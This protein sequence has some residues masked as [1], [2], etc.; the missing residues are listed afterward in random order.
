MAGLARKD[1]PALTDQERAGLY[2]CQ[3]CGLAQVSP[4]PQPSELRRH[5]REEYLHR[6]ETRSRLS[7]GKRRLFQHYLEELAGRTGGR[8][9]LDLGCGE[10]DFVAAAAAAGWDAVGLELHRGA[11]EAGAARGVRVFEGG[12][13]AL[14]P[15][16]FDAVTLWNV[17]DQMPD[18]ASELG[19]VLERLEPGGFLFVRVP[20]LAFHLAAWRAWRLLLPG[21]RPPTVFH[22]LVFDGSALVR[23]LSARGLEAV[24]ADNSALTE[25]PIP[26]L[27]APVAAALRPLS[28]GL[29]ALAAFLSGGRLL[30]AP[31]L[32]AWARR[33]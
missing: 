21:R 29:A 3:A 31:S 7:A 13:E 10:G 2:R 23:F 20:N 25:S 32:V 30:L 14:P 4:R 19:K 9:L 18:P 8:R 6:A 16:R 17:L 33:A 26:G 15:G 12:P 11:S 22:P 27:P 24:Q 5:Y 28:S 1:L